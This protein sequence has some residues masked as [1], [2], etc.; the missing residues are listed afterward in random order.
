[1]AETI[2]HRVYDL[3]VC[4]EGTHVKWH[5]VTMVAEWDIIESLDFFFVLNTMITIDN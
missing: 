4:S 2:D 1:M 3:D 5:M